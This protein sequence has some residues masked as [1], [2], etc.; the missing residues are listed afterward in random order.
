[1]S[2]RRAL[3]V[4]NN[5][6]LAETVAEILAG[7]GFEVDIASS[8]VEALGVWRR[9]PADLVV[10]DV[11]L[12]DIGGLRL[13]RRLLRRR[14]DCKLL[15]MSAGD[16]QVLLGPCERLGATLL[17]KPFSPAHLTATIRLILACDFRACP[18]A[19]AGVRPP[20]R[21]LGPRTP[22]ALLQQGRASRGGRS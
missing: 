3:V 22:R 5:A 1:M 12:P 21:L 7:S 11:D 14:A 9:R 2:L 18:V 13:A 15:V 10:L 8:G 19:R 4:D 16:P 6:G 17:T 20:R